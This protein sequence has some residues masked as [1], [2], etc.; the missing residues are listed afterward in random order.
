MD[1]ALGGGAAQEKQME[2]RERVRRECVARIKGAVGSTGI[3]TDADVRAYERDV[4][5]DRSLELVGIHSHEEKMRALLENKYTHIP[6][7]LREAPLLEQEVR[8][9]INKAVAAGWITKQSGDRWIRERLQNK[10][11]IYWKKKEFI[12]EKF[13]Q[14]LKNWEELAKDRK[15]V[16]EKRKKLGLKISDLPELAILERY[17]FDDAHF[18]FKRDAVNKALAVLTAHEQGV[19]N[20]YELA[21]GRLQYAIEKKALAPWKKGEWLRRIFETETD[22]NKIKDFVL[23]KGY[24]NLTQYIENWIKV[25]E[26][27]DKI[28]ERREQEWT[29][30]SFH[31]VSKK[32]FLEQHYEWREAYVE[33]AERRFNSIDSE[34]PDFLKIRHALDVKD[35]D[36]A[37]DLIKDAE[38]DIDRMSAADREKLNSMKKFL[39]AH[40]GPAAAEAE[41]RPSDRELMEQMDGL[42]AQVPE[43]QREIHIL[44]LK[45]GADSFRA[46][47]SLWYNRVWCWRHRFLNAQREEQLFEESKDLTAER[48]RHGHGTR[49]EANDTTGANNQQPAIRNQRGV[50]AAQWIFTGKDTGKNWLAK[51]IHE[52][53]DSH[54]FWYWTSIIPREVEY[55]QHLFVME[56]LHKPMLKIAKELE[57]RGLR[58]RGPA[59]SIAEAASHADKDAGTPQYSLSA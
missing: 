23:G 41:R 52:N 24:P 4:L 14:F 1:E 20:L 39:E 19:K 16:E 47:K 5:S 36:D 11:V 8:I 53:K 43:S 21:E 12:K 27:F 28:E 25:S 56:Q 6:E 18:K 10:N 34:R 45:Y 7:L 2:Q 37:A 3:I 49:H 54:N 42:I 46:F 26:R 48:I 13:P 40:R 32:F 17:G 9:S 30:R 44:M 38:R 33:E 58:Y 35:W 15:I 51:T 22:E 50:R 31:F 57:K 59:L 29:P 55:G